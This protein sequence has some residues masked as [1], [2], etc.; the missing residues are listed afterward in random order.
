MISTGKSD[1]PSV[2]ELVSDSLALPLAAVLL[3]APKPPRVEHSNHSNDTVKLPGVFDN[4]SSSRIS[5]LNGS[6]HTIS[7]D[8]DTDTVLVLPDYKVVTEVARTKEGA[9][10]LYRHSLDPTV[11]RIGNVFADLTLQSWVLPYACVILLCV[12]IFATVQS[13]SFDNIPQVHISVEII[14]VVS[15]LSN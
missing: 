2:I 11:T 13:P 14:D 12:Y 3:A 10:Q 6:H 1:W 7:D 8:H 9:E 5:V 4:E 15:Q